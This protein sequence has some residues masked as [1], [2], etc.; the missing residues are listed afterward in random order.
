MW[1]L[2]L[3]ILIQFKLKG[4]C[5]NSARDIQIH[6]LFAPFALSFILFSFSLSLY[7]CVY[8]YVYA[9]FFNH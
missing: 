1:A 6:Q 4:N 7:M 2:K 8:T 9:Y 5:Q 3:F